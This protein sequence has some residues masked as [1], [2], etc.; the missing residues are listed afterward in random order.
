MEQDR[1]KWNGRYGGEG[2]FLGPHP[3]AFLAEQ[4]ALV[5]A[6]LP[7]RK[8]LDIACGEGRN[9]IYLAGLG[10]DVT[11]MDISDQGLAKASRWA[12]EEGVDI[13]FIREDLEAVPLSG[14]WDLILNF[15]F[16]LRD[17]IPQE[18]DALNPGGVILFET[19]LDSANLP[20]E[21]NPEFFL[22]PGELAG[23]FAR[24]AGTIH[25]SEE[26]FLAGTAVSRLLFQK[27][28]SP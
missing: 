21:H 10:F 2:F 13:A 26:C 27:T 28:P 1:I 4:I 8:A 16:L 12:T 19:L 24:F 9:S 25:H 20:G 3:S 15:N 23:I 17:L 11:G 5:E 22:Q 18:V 14:R 7:G 6:M